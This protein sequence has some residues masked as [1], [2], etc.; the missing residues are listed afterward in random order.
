MPTTLPVTVTASPRWGLEPTLAL[1][2]VLARQGF[3]MVPH[4]AARLV[5]SEQHLS[6]ILCRLDEADVRDVFVVAGDGATPVGDFADS[7]QL[8][9]AI[10]RLRQGGFGRKQHSVGITGYPEGHPLICE[11]DLAL[12]LHSKQSLSSYV[13]T[14]MCFDAEAVGHWIRH[15]RQLGVRLPVHAGVA[16]AVDR[17]KLL[18]IAG[19]IGVGTSLAFLRKQHGG[20]R[21][22]RS[23]GYRPDQLVE[24][25]AA[26]VGQEG[27]GISGLHV[28]TLGDV[29]ATERWRRELLDRLTAGGPEHG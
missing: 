12:A 27:R 4:L 2:E 17:L 10:E 19:R 22:L 20:A 15:V 25:L 18:R 3:S 26:G 13:V 7:L 24:A 16:G 29:A 1:T 14:Q 21:L 28:Y 11:G 6:E 23:G 5:S 8:L 9:T